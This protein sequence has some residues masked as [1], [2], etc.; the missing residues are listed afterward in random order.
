MIFDSNS[1]TSSDS[2]FNFNSD[3]SPCNDEV[4]SDENN[5][6][7]TFDPEKKEAVKEIINCIKMFP[8]EYSI[9]DVI[10]CVEVTIKEIDPFLKH[11]ANNVKEILS[12]WTKIPPGG[13]LR[14]IYS[15]FLEL[16][17]PCSLYEK[18][19]NEEKLFEKWSNLIRR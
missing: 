14:D 4:V 10:R 16:Q 18:K 9:G 5:N 19:Q 17:N 7:I 1:N 3:S 11:T 8:D 6:L 13:L 15:I 2:E 12:N